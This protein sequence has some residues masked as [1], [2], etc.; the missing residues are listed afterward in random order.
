MSLDDTTSLEVIKQFAFINHRAGNKLKKRIWELTPEECRHRA[1]VHESPDQNDNY[2]ILTLKLGKKVL[3]LDKV[4]QGCSRLRV[5]RQQ[6][7]QV[8]AQLLNSVKNGLFDEELQHA[9]VSQAKPALSRK[10]IN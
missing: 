9:K 1:R 8:T 5:P 7:A 2:R 3:Q 4:A 6:V 10:Q